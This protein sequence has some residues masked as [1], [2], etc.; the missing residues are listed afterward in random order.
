MGDAGHRM[1][2]NK[3]AMAQMWDLY[4][5]GCDSQIIDSKETWFQDGGYRALEL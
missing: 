5:T 3:D 2:V 1:D 4:P